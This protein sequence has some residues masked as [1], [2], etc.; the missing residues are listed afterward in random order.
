MTFPPAQSPIE[1]TVRLKRQFKMHD[2]FTLA[3]VYISPIVALYAV[4]G[5]IVQAAGPAGWWVFPIGLCLQLLIAL[6]LGVMVSRWPL[7]GGSYQWA[8]RLMGD[9]YG[10]L[11]GWFYIW[12]LI[13]VF[14]SNGYAIASFIPAAL[15]IEAFTTST[16]IYIALSIVCLATVLNLLGPGT[17]KLLGKLSLGAE[18]IG[19]LGLATVLLIWHRQHDLDILFTTAGAGG[20]S[21]VLGGLLVALGFVGF[22]LAGFESVCSMAEEVEQP[23]KNIPK[24]IIGALLAIGIIVSYCALALI[25]ATPDFA[26]IVSGA[27]VD[28]AASTIQAAFG[29]NIARVFFVLVI[30]GFAA[31]MM[32]AQTS[33]SRVIWAFS[34]DRILPGSEF[35]STLS[36]KHR[37]PNRAVILVGALAVIVTLLAFSE[38]VYATLISSATA[39]F[40]ITMGFAVLGLLYRL[41]VKKWQAGTFSLASMTLPVVI[42]AACWIVFEIA[43]SAWPREVVGQSWYVSWAVFIGIS[44]VGLSG[45]A[46]WLSIR[47]NLKGSQAL[48][49]SVEHL[50]PDEAN[51]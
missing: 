34:R 39:T 51:G 20:D 46:V 11:T 41:M 5:L 50:L 36:S 44:L 35:L 19:S 43:N 9:N 3:F 26:A 12:T 42:G 18:V 25:L 1:T 16:Q 49:E 24:A 2:A 27:I 17:L 33:V 8:R 6:S 30:I 14:A 29:E 7:Q 15:G 32:M 10:W 23:E 21:Y 37:T 22:G 45:A 31:S 47:K 48:S 40:F 13:F 4:F 28:P 38:R